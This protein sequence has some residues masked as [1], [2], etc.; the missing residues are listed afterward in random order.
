MAAVLSVAEVSKSFGAVQAL[1]KVTFEANRGECIAIL[2]ENGAGK[3][4]L[5][6][7]LMGLY[8]PD[9]GQVA[10]DGTPCELTN[11]S[12]ALDNGIGMIHQHFSLVENMTAL[13]NIQIG[14]PAAKRTQRALR[15]VHGICSDFGF[16]VDFSAKVEDMPVGMKQRVEIIKALYRN[17]SILILD[18][19]TSV[20]A[21]TEVQ[22]FL[23]EIRV[24]VAKGLT[25]LLITHKLEEI[26][27]AADRVLIMRHGRIEGDLVVSETETHQ[28]SSLMMGSGDTGADLSQKVLKEPG[29][30]ISNE[31]ALALSSV[32]VVTE[33]GVRLL[34]D[35]N[36]EI[37]KGEILGVAGIDGNGQR[38]LSEAIC[39][40]LEITEGV[41]VLDGTDITSQTISERIETGIGFVPEDR[42]AEGLVLSLSVAENTAIRT[43]QDPKFKNGGFVNR[44]AIT[45]YADDLV[46]EYD[47]RPGDPSLPASALSGGNQQKVVLGREI[48]TASR[49]LVVVQPTKGL[50]V[51]ATRFV[52]QKIL[53]ASRRGVAVLYISTELEHVLEVSDRVAVIAFGRI[54][55]VVDPTTTSSQEIGMLMTA[56]KGE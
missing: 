44:R 43:I 36:L 54:S 38:E 37:S 32:S 51:G 3:T 12:V 56:S 29:R 42:H 5:A 55:G 30:S 53:E 34:D 9:Q 4:S 22:P 28:M 19:P 49:L 50:D 17:V 10:L 23:D 18:E 46:A 40:I 25:V 11:P 31:T 35:I 24:M 48:E 14:L 52:Q 2:G 16:D 8:Q 27:Q 1:N 21:P 47:I 13:E 45:S 15:D 33:N 41:I 7:V 6:S 20:L 26:V 39:G